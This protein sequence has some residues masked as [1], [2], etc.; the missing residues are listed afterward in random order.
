MIREAEDPTEPKPAMESKKIGR[1]SKACRHQSAARVGSASSVLFQS[2]IVQA[3]MKSDI[4]HERLA[5][6]QVPM[7]VVRSGD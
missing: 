5:D 3:D 7:G 4:V 1:G 6:G 2:L